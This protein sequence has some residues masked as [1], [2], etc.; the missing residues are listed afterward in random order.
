[1]SKIAAVLLLL[2]VLGLSATPPASAGAGLWKPA[3]R[4]G[5]IEQ[6]PRQ[7]HVRKCFPRQHTIA[8]SRAMR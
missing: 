1:M 3:T 8:R 6:R 7:A 5:P 4:I 2:G